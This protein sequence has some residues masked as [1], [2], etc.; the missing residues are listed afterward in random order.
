MKEH[1]G[2]RSHDVV[3]LL[4]MISMGDQHWYN[5]DLAQQLMISG[6]EVTES[7]NRSRIAKLVN[8]K[9]TR[10]HVLAFLDLVEKGLPYVFPDSP[11][12]L[13]IGVPTAHST[14]PLKEI[15]A[16]DLAY[17]WPFANGSVRGQAISP[18]HKNVPQAALNDPVLHEL[19]ALVDAL[20]VGRS[21]EKNLAIKFLKERI[22]AYQHNHQP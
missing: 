3:I 11:S 20:R 13:T 16:S 10:V 1:K 9:K 7:L 21:R 12:G 8:A 18:L 17:V 5:K 2:M 14:S 22:D 6:S 4:K 15:I 19:L